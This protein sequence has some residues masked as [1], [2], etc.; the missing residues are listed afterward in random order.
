MEL[1][2]GTVALPGC[3]TGVRTCQASAPPLWVGEDPE[4]GVRSPSGCWRP[5]FLPPAEVEVMEKNEGVLALLVDVLDRLLNALTTNV[6]GCARGL[7]RLPRGQRPKTGPGPSPRLGG[8][9]GS[10]GGMGGLGRGSAP[11]RFL[12]SR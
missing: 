3:H 1:G 4:E 9:G 2:E 5:P 6:I 7:G 10:Q 12:S 11:L 8:T